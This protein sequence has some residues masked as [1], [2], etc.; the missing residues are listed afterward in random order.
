[1][2]DTV[3]TTQCRAVTKITLARPEVHNALN[4]AMIRE[5][6]ETFAAAGADPTTRAVVLAAEG[7]SFCAGGDL[8]WMREAASY[9]PEENAADALRLGRMLKTIWDCPKPVI[10]RVQGPAYGGGVGLLAACDLVAA[11]E[12]ANLCFSEVRLGLVPAV[13]T[14]FVLRKVAPGAL[15]RYFLTAERIPAAEGRRLGLVSEVVPT[16]E[17]LDSLISAWTGTLLQNG[18]QAMAGCKRVLDALPALDWD[19]ALGY[20][21]Q[22]LAERRAS[23]EGREGV[24]AFL[25]KR[26]PT[27]RPEAGGVP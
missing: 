21:S 16:E 4:A 12:T 27:W 10:A 24:R 19:E 5:L 25:E 13:I 23:E 6:T 8:Q 14:P 2:S 11:T 3:R 22:Q 18:P 17:E 7:K 1:M 20:T 9:T 26:A 15:R